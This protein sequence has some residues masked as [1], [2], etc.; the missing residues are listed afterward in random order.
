MKRSQ[1]SG[2]TLIELLVVIAIIAIL[3]AMLLPALASAKERAH[4]GACVNNLRQIGTG[5]LIY[6]DDYNA[7]YP[8]TQVSS[9]PVNY[10]ASGQYTRW[11][12]TWDKNAK[13]PSTTEEAN[14]AGVL[15]N[16]TSLGYLYLMKLAGDGGVF[17]CPSLD[18]KGSSFGSRKYAPLLTANYQLS[19]GGW[20]VFSSYIYNPV[21][22]NAANSDYIRKYQKTSDL[23]GRRCFGMDF[24]DY[25]CF[26]TATKTFKTEIK[27]FAHGRNKGMNVLFS[28]GSVEFKKM[29]PA[30]S[31]AWYNTGVTSSYD[32]AALAAIASVFETR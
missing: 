16:F 2:F 5:A 15:A 13:I 31:M 14:K 30:V 22:R 26:D 17:Y 23:D 10:V 8:V 12:F 32:A 28:D 19:T 20:S 4:R 3:A 9:H 6:A 7:W 21:V 18:A 27:D 24:V 29:I 11:I 25:T 1:A